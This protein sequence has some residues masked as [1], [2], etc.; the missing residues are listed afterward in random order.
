MTGSVTGWWVE[1]D[2]VMGLAQVA[3]ETG[4]WRRRW[5][6]WSAFRSGRLLPLFFFLSL[7]VCLQFFL[8]P[9]THRCRC[10]SLLRYTIAYARRRKICTLHTQVSL[11]LSRFYFCPTHCTVFVQYNQ[12]SRSKVAWALWNVFIRAICVKTSITRYWLYKKRKRRPS[13]KVG[14]KN[15]K[16]NC[17]R[18]DCWKRR[19][20]NNS[21]S[22]KPKKWIFFSCWLR[23]FL[24]KKT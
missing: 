21:S 6:A 1:L 23:Y 18:H 4:V 17:S 5:R 8:L 24:L 11:S 16:R 9:K 13:K 2:R 3:P 7:P 19:N 14:K 12:V 15:S 20:A 10:V 22:W